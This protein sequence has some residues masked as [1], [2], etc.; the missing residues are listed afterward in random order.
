MIA[1][2][3]ALA[4]I[5]LVLGVLYGRAGFERLAN[6]QV[7]GS[8]YACGA[9]GTQTLALIADQRVAWL[10]LSGICMT[11]FCWLNRQR[12]GMAR[13]GVALV[14]VGVMLNLAVMLANDG[15]MPVAPEALAIVQG[16]SEGQAGYEGP[17]KSTPIYDAEAELHWLGDRLLLPGPL[18]RIA[19]WSIG[20]VVMLIGIVGLLGNTMRGKHHAS[21]KPNHRMA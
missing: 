13:V 4:L 6:M 15:V 16:V 5:L 18:A 9:L 17:A 14:F 12:A 2:S 21:A 3:G 11:I 1:L 7:R 8:V 19:A 10:L 20:D